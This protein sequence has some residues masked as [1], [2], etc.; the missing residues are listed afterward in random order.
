LNE[1]WTWRASAALAVGGVMTSVL[2]AGCG[3]AGAG[4]VDTH[5][6]MP[7]QQQD[8]QKRLEP[9]VGRGLTA[10]NGGVPPSSSNRPMGR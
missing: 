3:G 9:T 7:V 2:L 6:Q 5:G 8:V 1:Q 4:Q 10:P